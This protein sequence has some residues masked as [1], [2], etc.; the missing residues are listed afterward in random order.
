MALWNS[1]SALSLLVAAAGSPGIDIHPL[2]QVEAYVGKAPAEANVLHTVDLARD[3]SSSTKQ[4][5]VTRTRMGRDSL[6]NPFRQLERQ[7]LRLEG[8]E[9]LVSR[10]IEA[11][12]ESRIR[13]VFERFGTTTLVVHALDSIEPGGR[14]ESRE[15]VPTTP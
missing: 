3:G 9:D 7:P 8:R 14:Q 12:Q 1:V 4:L 6:L 13:G 15:T 5:L 11:P 2:M 10:V